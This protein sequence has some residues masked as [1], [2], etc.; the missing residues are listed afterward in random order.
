MSE[1]KIWRITQIINNKDY[2]IE[3]LL[4]AI[5][6]I[7]VTARMNRPEKDDVFIPTQIS[8]VNDINFDAMRVEV[9][10]KYVKKS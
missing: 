4:V 6:E 9:V 1:D 2:Y 5:N 7:G 10:G 8:I 3:T